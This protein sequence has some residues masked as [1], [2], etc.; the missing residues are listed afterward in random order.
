MVDVLSS[1]TYPAFKLALI[2]AEV[3]PP[4][5]DRATTTSPGPA[6]RRTDEAPPASPWCGAPGQNPYGY[7]VQAPTNDIDGQPRPT[8]GRWDAGSDQYLP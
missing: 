5:P 8:A 4:T 7:T 6:H 3:L 1:R 2:T